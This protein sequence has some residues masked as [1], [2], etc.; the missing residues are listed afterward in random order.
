MYQVQVFR[1]RRW[2][3]AGSYVRDSHALRSAATMRANLPE[4]MT[5]RVLDLTGSPLPV[6]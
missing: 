4:T 5:V 3:N 6:S 1:N 2:Q